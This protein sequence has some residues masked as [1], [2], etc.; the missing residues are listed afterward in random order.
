MNIIKA[1][2]LACPVDGVRLEFRDKHFDCENGHVFDI[3]RQGYVNL[4]PVQ[5]KRSKQPGDSKAMVVARAEFL[6]SGV[7]Q[8]VAEQLA[9]IVHAQ[10]PGADQTCLLDA[11]CGEGYYLDY[12]L[13]SLQEK[14]VNSDLAFVGLDISKDAIIRAAKRNRQITW[15][16]GTNRQPPL[17]PVSVDIITCVFG[18]QSFEGFG[19]VL[20]PGGRVVL[21]E[22]GPEHL[23]E[24]RELIY[25]DVRKTEP[26]GLPRADENVYSVKDRQPLQFKTGEIDN[27]LI[28]QLLV[29]TPHFYRANKAGREAAQKLQALA[30]TVDVVFTVLEKNS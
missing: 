10:L 5:H 30:L 12:L 15:L 14:K 17:M 26:P 23:K 13:N 28:N 9:D 27:H 25:T 6:D 18:F 24:L 21:V 7:Y 4:L 19:K 29:M 16:V 8:P 11:G 20:R 22:P 2:N 1:D 3:A